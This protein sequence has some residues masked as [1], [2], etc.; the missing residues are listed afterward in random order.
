V[1]RGAAYADFDRDGDLDIVV[2]TN[3]G[4]AYL[5][6]ND[7]GN[8]NRWI[9]VTL[10]GTKSNRSG[11][12]AV[13][14]VT[15]AGGRQMQTVHSGSSYCSQS[16]LGLTFGLGQD[17]TVDA[18]DIDWPSGIKQRLTGISSNQFVTIRER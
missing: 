5:F 15:S 17:K 18:I 12:G 10:V 11:I 6:R 16:E 13:V 7:G 1:A 9:H 14:R 8:R 3:N 4:P 2:S